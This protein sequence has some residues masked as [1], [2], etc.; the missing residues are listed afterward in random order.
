MVTKAEYRQVRAIAR[1]ISGSNTT[2]RRRCENYWLR[3]IRQKAETIVKRE[4]TNKRTLGEQPG[5]LS[6]L[7]SAVKRFFW[8]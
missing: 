1:Q 5:M 7:A 3:R 2:T 6:R 8:R 4:P